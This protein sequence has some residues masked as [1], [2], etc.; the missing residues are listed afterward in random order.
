[1]QY[2]C[3]AFALGLRAPALPARG[4]EARDEEDGR[5]RESLAHG[6]SCASRQ[7]GLP[8]Q[9]AFHECGSPMLNQATAAATECTNMKNALSLLPLQERPPFIPEA[10]LRKLERKAMELDADDDELSPSAAAAAVARSSASAASS[11][12]TTTT[13]DF[14]SDPHARKQIDYRNKLRRNIKTVFFLCFI[15]TVH[16]YIEFYYIRSIS[17][18]LVSTV[19]CSCS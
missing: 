16:E 6:D 18:V 11:S 7:Q 12:H 5:H 10:F 1:M 13:S 9:L 4:G 14:V 17:S 19:L 2:N 8:C 3:W 15:H